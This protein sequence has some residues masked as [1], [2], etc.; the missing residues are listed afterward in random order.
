MSLIKSKVIGDAILPNGMKMIHVRTEHKHPKEFLLGFAANVVMSF[1]WG[2][3]VKML[4]DDKG[5]PV[6]LNEKT[7]YTLRELKSR[8]VPVKIPDAENGTPMIVKEET[9]VIQ[10]VKKKK[11]VSKKKKVA[12]VKKKKKSAPAK[13]K[14]AR[15]HQ[16]MAA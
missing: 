1:Y 3:V 14:K 9:P 8:E 7:V 4:T 6:A 13:K 16:K 10:M 12:P 5:I 15:N 2:Q 11:V